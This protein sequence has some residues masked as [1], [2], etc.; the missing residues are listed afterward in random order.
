LLERTLVVDGAGAAW[1]ECSDPTDPEEQLL[2]ESDGVGPHHEL[3]VRGLRADSRYQ[4]VVHLD[5]RSSAATFATGRPPVPAF[6]VTDPAGASEPYTLFNTQRGATSVDGT[7]LLIVDPDGA[8]RW[9]YLVGFD[10]IGDVDA[11][12]EDEGQTVH[13]GGG[14]GWFDVDQPNRGVFRDV[15]LSGQTLLDRTEPAF[16]LGFNHHS[17]K[18][19]D[20]SYLSL[21]GAENT[22]GVTTWYGVG[23]E[24][25]HPEA[26]L[27][28]TWSSQQLVDAGVVA[29][30]EPTEKLPFH[31][32]SVSFVDDA[33]GS[34]VW[35][36]LYGAR[37]IWRLDRATGDRTH[38]F[39]PEGD[40]TLLDPQGAPLGPEQWSWVQHDPDYGPD[41]SILLYDNGQDRPVDVPYSRVAEF[42][43]DLDARTATLL[44]D[45]TEPGWYDPVLGDAD[46][47]PNGDVLVTRGFRVGW[48]P[49][50]PDVSQVLELRPPRDGAAAEVVWRLRWT[51]PDWPTFRAA[52]YDGCAL[53]AN[54]RYCPAVAARLR[55]LRGEP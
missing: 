30:P 49:D 43:V 33:W 28:W 44:W 19:D 42:A 21:T 48:T 29:P 6:E 50:S 13:L 12:L 45:W 11:E 47:L 24:Q 23:I 8:V 22:D 26:G 9:S 41:G 52:R 31:A 37:Q 16:G 15:D 35:V 25:W 55:A 53:F 27:Q 17:E 54:A 2:V 18:L 34:A 46:W 40:L 3:V 36:S 4:C 5:G 10:L 51:D 20:G 14:W 38:V 7:W 1:A 39:G 32:N